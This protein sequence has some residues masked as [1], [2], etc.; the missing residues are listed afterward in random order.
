MLFPAYPFPSPHSGPHPAIK[1]FPIPSMAKLSLLS[2]LSHTLF[3]PS[4][5]DQFQRTLFH[6]FSYV[7]SLQQSTF[8]TML[9]LKVSSLD[10]HTTLSW[11]YTH[12]SGHSLFFSLTWPLQLVLKP[13][14]WVTFS[15]HCTHS[16]KVHLI[17]SQNTGAPLEFW[18]FSSAT[19]LL[20]TN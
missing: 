14:F 8:L 16:P 15:A 4:S 13:R 9:S 5:P 2:H 19:L 3:L 7:A 17:Y 12:I 1:F 18:W 10:F 6:S 20:V 11:F